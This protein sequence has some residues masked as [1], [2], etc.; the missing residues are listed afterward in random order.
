[1]LSGVAAHPESCWQ[2]GARVRPGLTGGLTPGRACKVSRWPSM[3]QEG[4]A[5]FRAVP[6]DLIY[7]ERGRGT[8]P[9]AGLTRR[10]PH[11]SNPG[12]R[13]GIQAADPEACTARQ[14]DRRKVR[15]RKCWT[16]PRP[17]S[18]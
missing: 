10:S 3:V 12:Y 2:A 16:A 1:M 8:P 9:P 13:V 15:N 6:G 11:V 14:E 4:A 17:R 5:R 18:R 7:G